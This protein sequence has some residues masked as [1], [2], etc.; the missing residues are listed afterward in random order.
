MSC[1]IVNSSTKW[2]KKLIICDTKERGRSSWGRKAEFVKW[3]GYRGPW[4]RVPWD[5]HNCA[6]DQDSFHGSGE[7]ASILFFPVLVSAG[8]KL[9]YPPHS[10][11]YDAVFWLWEKK[12]RWQH[13]DVSVVAE[14]RLH[15]AKDVTTSCSVLTV[16]GL[17][18]TEPS[19]MT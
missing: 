5:K 9:L 4:R 17:E 14:Q 6:W 11:W 2:Q 3:R 12:Q 8:T 15:K 7:I 10:V 18:E 16:R 13:T 1:S 19:Q